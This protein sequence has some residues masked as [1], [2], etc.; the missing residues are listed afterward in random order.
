MPF[1]RRAGRA[2]GG[3]RAIDKVEAGE[4]EPRLVPQ[5]DQVEPDGQAFA[6]HP[7]DVVDDA[8]ERA[9]GQHQQL[10]PVQLPGRQQL[11]LELAQAS[12]TTSSPRTTASPDGSRHPVMV[13]PACRA[14]GLQRLAR[15]R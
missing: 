13:R 4:G 12:T 2:H 3:A 10:D 15:Y 8:V 11:G 6:H 7:P 1:G 5:E 9:V 14:A